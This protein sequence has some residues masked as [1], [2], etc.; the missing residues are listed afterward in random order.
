MMF[1]IGSCLETFERLEPCRDCSSLGEAVSCRF[2]WTYGGSDGC[3]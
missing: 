2:G 3:A 1:W